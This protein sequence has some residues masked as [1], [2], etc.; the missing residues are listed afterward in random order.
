MN[1]FVKYQLVIDLKFVRTVKMRSVA[2]M[3]EQIWTSTT[4]EKCIVVGGG[5]FWHGCNEYQF[6]SP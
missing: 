6:S 1:K 5:L 2:P 4:F 3:P